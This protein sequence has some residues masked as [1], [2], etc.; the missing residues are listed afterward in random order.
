M[1]HDFDVI[2]I[3]A[4]HAGTEAA[5]AATRRGA[6]VA[7]VT[8]S[9]QDLGVM[10]CNPAIGGIGKG[11]LVREIDALGGLMGRAADYAGIQ[12][13]LLNRKKGPAVRGP[14]AQSDR[15]RYAAFVA[16]F[17]KSV[18]N[19]TLVFGKVVK[20]EL[21]KNAISGV[22]LGDGTNLSASAV[23]LTSGTFLDG[24]TF[25]GSEFRSEGRVGG[26]S[27]PELAGQLR[28]IVPHFGRLK[29][30]TP[31]RISSKSIHWDVCGE[32]E[33]DPDPAF[34]SHWTTKTVCQQINCGV[35][36]TNPQTHEIIAKNLEASAM[37]GGHIDGIGP[38]Y[39]P[40]VEDKVVRFADKDAHQIFLEPEGIGS[41]VVY[42]NGI[43]TSLPASVQKEFVRSIKGLEHADIVQ[44]GY[45]VEY[46]YVDPRA[47]SDTLALR[48]FEGLF[49]A[50]QINGTTGYEEAAAQGL[51]AG[52]NAAA[53]T[54]SLD[55]FQLSR[56]DA[57]IGVM[58]DDLVTLGVQEPYRMFTSRAE[59]RLT[60]RSDN[61]DQRL[62]SL[63]RTAGLVDDAHWEKFCADT[64][65]LSSL[66]ASLK[67]I[68]VP[69]E[70]Q[71]DLGAEVG[72][73]SQTQDLLSVL[74][75][76]GVT[77]EKVLGQFPGRFSKPLIEKVQAEAIYA[78]Y[79][80]RQLQQIER[81]AKDSSFAIPTDLNLTKI[82]GLSNELKEKLNRSRPS[83]LA[84]ASRIDGMTPAALT[85]LLGAAKNCVSA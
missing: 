50:G 71:K 52:A 13:R 58:I 25:I 67:S 4:G 1:K 20:F 30:G 66:R 84:Q 36:E 18:P 7:L 69:T 79:L 75:L 34:F 51:I 77:V 74:G 33:G 2:V 81:L 23:V 64:D 19:L 6:K 32:Q 60:L 55:S 42:P 22:I 65:S 56:S 10:S 62:T 49:L 57:Y 44:M 47:L 38:R 31:P 35:T 12:F 9:K 76:R 17:L 85:I 15:A 8:M 16:Q 14:R 45:A 54:L 59:F 27:S 83:N 63:G 48:G 78:P 68:S 80:D 37:Y 41:Q 5:L 40:S 70:A 53:Q 73:A 61:A 43:S 21:A 24:K 3:G 11:H 72:K 82:E 39:C 28:E 29:T 46:D 26:G